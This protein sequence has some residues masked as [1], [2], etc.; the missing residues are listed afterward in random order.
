MHAV[1]TLPHMLR[2][3]HMYITYIDMSMLQMLTGDTLFPSQNIEEDLQDEKQVE[4]RF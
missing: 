2:T 4:F 3:R 1:H